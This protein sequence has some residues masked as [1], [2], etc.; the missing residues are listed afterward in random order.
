MAAGTNTLNVMLWVIVYVPLIIAALWTIF[1]F[2]YYRIYEK[3]FA[4]MKTL[5]QYILAGL[6]GFI[7]LVR[8]NPFLCL[9]FVVFVSTLVALGFIM[10]TGLPHWA[11]QW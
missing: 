10:N 2:F 1:A 3:V 8:N 6:V 7:S 11:G 4:F 5:G 9:A